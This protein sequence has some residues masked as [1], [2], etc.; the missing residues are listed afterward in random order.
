MVTHS[1]ILNKPLLISVF[2]TFRVDATSVVLISTYDNWAL[3]HIEKIIEINRFN[4]LLTFINPNY[5]HGKPSLNINK[6][7]NNE[8]GFLYSKHRSRTVF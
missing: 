7:N 4:S 1:H 6:V 3:Y 2:L 8:K 5:Y